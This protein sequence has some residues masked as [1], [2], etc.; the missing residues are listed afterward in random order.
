MVGGCTGQPPKQVDDV[1]EVFEEKSGWYK[2]ARRSF[3]KW[4]VPIHVQMAILRQESRFRDDAQPP[5]RRLLGVIP[6]TRPSSAYGYAQAKDATWDWYIQ[7]TGNRGADR[8]DFADATDFV[9]WYGNTSHRMLGISKWDTYSQYL[10]YHEGQGGFKRKTYR[11]K[12]WLMKV[13]RRVQASAK[14]YS[15]QLARCEDGLDR[16]WSLWPF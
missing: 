4:G 3:K 2:D 6:W 1:C 12:P 14:Q 5:R 9:G 13:A 11:K 8:D 15:M 16:G 10:A 7:K